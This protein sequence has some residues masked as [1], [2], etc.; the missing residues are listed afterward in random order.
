M[1]ISNIPQRGL[2]NSQGYQIFQEK[3][4]IV[5]RRYQMVH[6]GSSIIHGDIK[7]SMKAVN[8]STEVSNITHRGLNISWR[9]QIF[10]GGG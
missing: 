7:Y 6:R 1:E 2:T 5:P 9:Y 3:G 4:L 8:H 10:H